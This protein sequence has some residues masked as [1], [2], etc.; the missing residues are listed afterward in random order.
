MQEQT[1]LGCPDELVMTPNRDLESIKSHNLNKELNKV[2]MRH[3]PSAETQSKKK[4]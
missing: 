1:T 2:A 3:T 4:V